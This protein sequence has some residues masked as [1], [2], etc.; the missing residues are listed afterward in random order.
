M[1]VRDL[2][3]GDLVLVNGTV[4][5]ICYDLLHQMTAKDNTNWKIEGLLLPAEFL[6]ANDFNDIN[7]GILSFTHCIRLETNTVVIHKISLHYLL[8]RK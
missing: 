2:Q 6:E 7:K 8:E 1:D 5:R 4:N 3:Y